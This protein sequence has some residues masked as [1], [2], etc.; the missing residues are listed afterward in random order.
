MRIGNDTF[1]PDGVSSVDLSSN[2]VSDG[3]P[4]EH[5][6]TMTI[7]LVFT[8]T[9]GGMFFLECSS[10]PFDKA[11]SSKQPNNWT[12]ITGSGQSVSEAGDHTWNVEDV[13]FAWVRVCWEFSGGTGTLETAQLNA[14]GF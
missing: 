9:P 5:V 10:E 8:G 7:Q 1:F 12:K 14:K 6:T 4:V 13:G 11:H 3:I 2:W